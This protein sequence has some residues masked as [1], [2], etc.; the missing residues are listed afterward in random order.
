MGAAHK[1]LALFGTWYQCS[2]Q[3]T[4]GTVAPRG[5]LVRTAVTFFHARN[6]YYRVVTS[7]IVRSYHPPRKIC[8]SSRTGNTC[9]RI[10]AFRVDSRFAPSQCQTTL[11]CK[12]VSY[13]LGA[14][15]E[16]ALSICPQ[17][18]PSHIHSTHQKLR[19]FI[20]GNIA[21]LAPNCSAWSERGHIGKRVTAVSLTVLGTGELW[22][23]FCE[24]VIMTAL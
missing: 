21:N 12:D 24:R 13:W 18:R 20:Y 11:L 22:G 14:S 2:E 23:V 7:F 17:L 10:P 9:I 5:R 3:A 15:L 6:C 1:D 8:H 19:D 4:S 16:S